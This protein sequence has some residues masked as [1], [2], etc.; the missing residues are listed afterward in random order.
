VCRTLV[1][2]G[3]CKNNYC[4]VGVTTYG[5]YLKKNTGPGVIYYIVMHL[6]VGS[7]KWQ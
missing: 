1:D 7:C 4:A 2:Y 5:A 3:R 6:F